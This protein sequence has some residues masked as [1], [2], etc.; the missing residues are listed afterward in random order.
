MTSETKNIELKPKLHF[1]CYSVKLQNTTMEPETFVCKPL[2]QADYAEGWRAVLPK[3]N[4]R[5][6]IYNWNVNF[7][8]LPPHLWDRCHLQYNHEG[9]EYYNRVS[10]GI[11]LYNVAITEHD[12]TFF[13]LN[14][15]L[16]RCLPDKTKVQELYN[17]VK[18]H[19]T[20]WLALKAKHFLTQ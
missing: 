8:Q 3:K 13:E 18:E 10:D 20:G 16:S 19:T 9:K 12:S 17:K 15:E 14:R 1:G 11:Y 5:S 7:S 4:K 6:T 2:T